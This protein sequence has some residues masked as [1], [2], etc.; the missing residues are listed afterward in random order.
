[1]KTRPLPTPLAFV[2][3]L[4]LVYLLYMLCRVVY[5]IEFWDLYAAGWQQLSILQLLRGGF[6]F[7][8]SAIFYTNLPYAA[9][10]LLPWPR[11]WYA[12]RPWQLVAKT[13][14]VVVNV[15]MLVI[16]LVDTVYSRYTGRR[17]TWTFFSE[18]SQEN[19]LG[20]IVGVE[21]ISHWYL[22]LIGLLFIAALILLYRPAKPFA[23]PSAHYLANSLALL[24]FLPLSIIAM[25]GGASTAIRPITISNANQYVNQ[26][27]QA[28]IVLNTPFSL[29]RTMG[30]TTFADPQYFTEE[31]LNSL[32]TPIHIGSKNYEVRTMKTKSIDTNHFLALSSYFLPQKN[33]VI[34]IVESL[35][36]EYIGY[37]N[38]Y[39]CQTPFLDSLIGQSLTFQNSFANGRKSIDAMP[40][41]LSGIPMFVEPFFVTNYSLNNVSGIAGELAREGYSTAF[42]HGAENS[43]MGFQAFA[44]TTGFQHYYGR[45][46]YDDDPRFRGRDDFDGTW[47]IWDEEFLQYFALMLDTL[48]QPFCTAL[49]TA[50]SHHPFVIPARYQD[51]LHADGH[52]MYTCIRYVDHALRH[53]FRT[54]SQMPWYRNTLFV[55]TA[56]HTNHSQ[57][58][59]YNNA[60]G[61]Y[62]VPIILFDPSGQLPRGT[63]PAVAQQTDIMPTLLGLLGYQKPYIAFGIDLLNTPADSTWAIHYNNGVYQLV[64]DQHLLL[65]DGTVP[66]AL[67]NLAA[68]PL[69]QHNLLADHQTP[70]PTCDALTTFAKA[71]I[72]SYMQ[73]MISNNLMY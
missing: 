68:D 1:M 35:A 70:P 31:K 11:K 45:N 56:D 30:K 41:I 58:P 61:P 24:L 13:L 59:A 15:L 44:R 72:Q 69:Q 67:Y 43:S 14:F 25:R 66:T 48:P 17:T 2:L 40:S 42:F 65:F 18:F 47:A 28:A 16:N 6:I 51:S 36:Q 29:I 46:E 53:F 57:Q 27:S 52:P 39:P 38:S 49:F 63:S 54:A 10:I 60:L 37:Y 4:A 62:R 8:S 33:V 22:L 5:I 19:N 34:L 20:D 23:R 12:S 50:T 73:R 71:V 32:Y 26:P 21:L 3:N 7:D 55:I 64:K 9:L